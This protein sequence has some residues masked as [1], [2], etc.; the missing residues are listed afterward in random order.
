MCAETGATCTA[1]LG[2]SA[3]LWLEN[4]L[5]RGRMLNQLLRGTPRTDHELA[6]TIRA[7]T[8]ENAVR[9]GRAEGAFERADFRGP[10][11]WRQIGIAA[12]AIGAQLKHRILHLIAEQRYQPVRNASSA[13]WDRLRPNSDANSPRV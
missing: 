9:T 6:T 3:P 13:E 5:S 10:G 4:T 11:I 7:T 8:R 12:F 2:R 1:F